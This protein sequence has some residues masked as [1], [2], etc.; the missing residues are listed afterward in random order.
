MSRQPCPAGEK[1]G[2]K[3]GLYLGGNPC[4]VCPQCLS[5]PQGGSGTSVDLFE[6][7]QIFGLSQW[8]VNSVDALTPDPN[9]NGP[10]PKVRYFDSVHTFQ[11]ASPFTPSSTRILHET[12]GPFPPQLKFNSTFTG[13]Q[14]VSNY[15]ATFTGYNPATQNIN[16]FSELTNGVCPYN[17]GNLTGINPSSAPCVEQPPDSDPLLTGTCTGNYTA[18]QYAWYSSGITSSTVTTVTEE[19]T[20]NI[21]TYV[22]GIRKTHTVFQWIYPNCTDPMWQPIQTEYEDGTDY[23]VAGVLTENI[24]LS[25]PYQYTDSANEA[26]TLIGSGTVSANPT[27]TCNNGYCSTYLNYYQTSYMARLSD[28]NVYDLAQMYAAGG[29]SNAGAGLSVGQ[30]FSVGGT[31]TFGLLQ[32]TVNSVDGNGGATSIT[33]TQQAAFYGPTALTNGVIECG[34]GLTLSAAPIA[35]PVAIT[36]GPY[37]LGINSIVS[38]GTGHQA[39]QILGECIVV[40]SVDGSG[41]VTAAH[42]QQNLFGLISCPSGTFT[43]TDGSGASFNVSLSSYIASANGYSQGGYMIAASSTWMNFNCDSTGGAACVDNYP[44]YLY[45]FQLSCDL[46]QNPSTT[47]VPVTAEGAVDL[48]SE[49]TFSPNDGPVSEIEFI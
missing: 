41:A 16:P 9:W 38:G 2:V 33:I 17:I 27:T 4:G 13:Y 7:I 24:V 48:R 39:G 28:G 22:F 43:P 23:I 12:Y 5:W 46:S 10:F 29:I 44:S 1:T 47:V 3:P 45:P 42:V 49:T 34:G 32:L 30:T 31:G 15:T 26:S 8:P 21:T 6:K 11:W 37:I 14:G 25:Q 40:D 36:Q 20:Q 19:T 18:T 35:L